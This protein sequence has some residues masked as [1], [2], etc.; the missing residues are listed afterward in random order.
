MKI[1]QF[2]KDSDFKNFKDIKKV[3]SQEPYNLIIKEYSDKY[4]LQKNKL[5][6]VFSHEWCYTCNGLILDKESNDII[7]YGSDCLYSIYN[8]V[9]SL[10]GKNIK[11]EKYYDGTL[12][13][14]FYYKNKWNY[15]TNGNGDAFK[16]YWKSK[17]SFGELF[18][19]CTDTDFEN[20]LDIN[21][22]Y[23]FILIH[24]ENKNVVNYDYRKTLLISIRDK[25]TYKEII[26]NTDFEKPEIINK[27]VD[28]LDNLDYQN[29]G[30]IITN[31]DNLQK[32][33]IVN[34]SFKYVS[35][36][37]NNTNNINK[38]C[39]FNILKNNESLIKYFPEYKFDYINNNNKVNELINT[40]FILYKERYIYKY[41][42]ILPS[43]SHYLIKNIHKHYLIN[44]DPINPIKIRDVL[45]Q[46]MT[47]KVFLLRCSEL[48][49]IQSEF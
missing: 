24:P 42:K 4:L 49:E 33:S 27:I 7:C 12:I 41:F 37:L 43:D 8:N 29:P 5:P 34:D 13:K 20:N 14:V 47:S 17:K 40:L 32:Y 46:L 38:I 25:N 39:I 21:N 18:L 45:I 9:E 35:E 23:T 1:S 11:I 6:N 30:Y 48:D 26:D 16:C 36:L 2:I 28:T 19:E 31:L 44:K 10:K 15:A 3:L 22:I